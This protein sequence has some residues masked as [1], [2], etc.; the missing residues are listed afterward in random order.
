MQ[1]DGNVY[2]EPERRTILRFGKPRPVVRNGRAAVRLALDAPE[3]YAVWALETNGRR[4]ER[5]PCEV[6]DGRLCFTADV[7]GAGGA[8]MLYEIARGNDE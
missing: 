6:R 1:A 7:N 5:V 8:R 2:A 3:G 4:A